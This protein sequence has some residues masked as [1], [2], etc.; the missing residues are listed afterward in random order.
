MKLKK[1]LHEKNEISAELF[2][3]LDDVRYMDDD[4]ESDYKIFKKD[5]PTITKKLKEKQKSIVDT[6]KK[7]Q[8]ITDLYKVIKLKISKMKTLNNPKAILKEYNKIEK[9]IITYN[10]YRSELYSEF[11]YT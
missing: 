3:A 5:I 10:K 8:K 7:V 11:I 1:W 9:I 4:M 2:N 6:E